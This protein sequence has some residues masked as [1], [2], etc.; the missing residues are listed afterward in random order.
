MKTRIFNVVIA[1]FISVAATGLVGC[2][3]TEPV[4]YN[5][6]VKVVHEPTAL[7]TVPATADSTTTTTQYSNGTVEKQ[8]TT[9]YNPGYVTA[10]P[11]YKTTVV[12]AP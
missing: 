4:A 2:Y 10:G 8:T 7:T 3:D 12:P 6:P 1:G 9:D 11:P 5:P